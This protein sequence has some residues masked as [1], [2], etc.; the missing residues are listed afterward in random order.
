MPIY[1][2]TQ[3]TKAQLVLSAKGRSRNRP[4]N[5]AVRRTLGVLYP[6]FITPDIVYVPSAEN[7]ADP[8]SRGDLGP[9]D[10]MLHPS[11]MLPDELK[12]FFIYE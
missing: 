3:T 6:L 4:I 10:K 5:L 7:L 9:T 11:F 2:S 8:I 12:S 1:V